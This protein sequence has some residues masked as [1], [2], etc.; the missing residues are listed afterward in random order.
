MRKKIIKTSCIFAA[1]A[2][3][4]GIIALDSETIIPLYI[5]F[6]SGGWLLV[7][8]YANTIW[9]KKDPTSMVQMENAIEECLEE[10]SIREMDSLEDPDNAIAMAAYA[11]WHLK[12]YPALN[13]LLRYIA[14]IE[15]IEGGK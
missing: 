6:L 4:L 10:I 11:A 12:E 9:K 13:R 14:G 3:L 7:V 8:L 5:S 2:F 15:E 1:V